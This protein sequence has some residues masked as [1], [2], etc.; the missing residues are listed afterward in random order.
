VQS[1]A[2]D[3]E[4]RQPCVRTADIT[5]E[6]HLIPAS[7]SQAIARARHQS[8]PIAT[9]PNLAASASGL[10]KLLSSSSTPANAVQSG[11]PL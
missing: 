4:K 7:P 1:L 5:C 8:F 6:N 2:F 9:V 11:S 3:L 10:L